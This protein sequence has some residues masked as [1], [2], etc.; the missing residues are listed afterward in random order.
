M[1]AETITISTTIDAS[2]DLK[3]R[4]KL[5]DV[6]T[7]SLISLGIGTGAAAGIVAVLLAA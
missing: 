1:N 2:A 6:V 3:T 4:K 7:L 5:R